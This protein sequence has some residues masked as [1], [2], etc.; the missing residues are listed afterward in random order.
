MLSRYTKSYE[1]NLTAID[2]FLWGAC[3]PLMFV[4]PDLYSLVAPAFTWASAVE[5]NE[6]TSPGQFA[7]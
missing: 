2:V 3:R 6:L 1:F 4:Q 7:K 5:T